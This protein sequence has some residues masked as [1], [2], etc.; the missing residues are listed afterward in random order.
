MLTSKNPTIGARIGNALSRVYPKIHDDVWR[1]R[2]W[3]DTRAQVR[4]LKPE[5]DRL[6]NFIE[7]PDR[8]VHLIVCPHHGPDAP[9]W[10]PGGGNHFFEVYQSA[11]EIL[12]E[13]SVTLFGV[14]GDES[15]TSWHRRFLE[16]L[17]ST[18]ATH[19]I[20]QIE[21]DPNQ[22]ENWSWDVI[23]S[24]LDAHWDGSLIG[25]MYDSAFHWLRLRTQRIGRIF[26][27]LLIGDICEPMDDFVKPGRSETGP[28]TMPLSQ[29]SV[30]RI[31]EYVAGLPKKYDVSF[32]GALYDY[33]VE[34][35]EQLRA[36]GF[37]VA[38][39]PHRADE[40]KTYDESRANQPTYLDYMAGLAQSELT[41]NFSLASGGPHEQYKIRVQ[42]ASLVGCI[43]L[44]DDKERSRIFFP[45]NE[46]AYFES[47]STLSAVV[48]QRLADREKLHR[49]QADARTRAHELAKYDFWGRLEVGL[50]R[51]G[52][53]PLTG[54]R[55]PLLPADES[56]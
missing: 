34:L 41:I 9:N 26:S 15:E 36:S 22:P 30:A 33:R 12:G 13:E 35:I 21:N 10:F 11:I 19:I 43:C 53:R 25:M 52:M 54:L 18:K 47:I 38:V 29:T 14:A 27:G 6:P 44:T 28:I 1:F 51:R 55:P 2:R 45:P 3:Q 16:T 46:Y 40:T 23:A 5:I 48:A 4:L 37:G 50:V 49:D 8:P 7:A 32:I 56:N 42:E 17:G 24:I 39:N 20:A 31:D